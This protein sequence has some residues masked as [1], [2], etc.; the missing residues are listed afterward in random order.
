LINPAPGFYDSR[1]RFKRLT[2]KAGV[3]IDVAPE[4]LLFLDVSTGFKAGGFSQAVSLT[5][6]AKLAP[7]APERVTAYTAGLKN[8]FLNN[9]L[10][11]NLEAFYLD[12]KDLQFSAQA[13]DGAGSIVLLTQNAGKARIF[14]GNIN[15]VARPWTGASIHGSVEYN[16]S[17][18]TQFAVT[19]LALFVPPGRVGCPVSAPDSSGLVT[20]DCSGKPLVRSMKWSGN[21]GVTQVFDLPNSGNVTI[22]GDVTVGGPRY[23]S[24]DFTPEQY[25]KGYANVSAS[26]T[27]NAPNDRW[28][29]SAFVRNLTNVA[30]FN[31]GGFQSSFVNGW[32]T[33]YIQPPRTY[34]GRIGVKF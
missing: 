23:L 32:S 15:V 16:N 30:I 26:L 5:D 19:E 10:Q 17:K 14:G 13:L 11:V 33:N 12:Y 31:G 21:A 20:I 7:Y 34:G 9:K 4:S 22:D 27:Y 3:E 18:Y 29:V 25:V 28:F 24:T 2:W 1:A 6:P 8:R